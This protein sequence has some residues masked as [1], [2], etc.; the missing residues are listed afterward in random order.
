MSRPVLDGMLTLHTASRTSDA[1]SALRPPGKGKTHPVAYTTW[2]LDG[3]YAL[4][5]EYSRIGPAREKESEAV[6]DVGLWLGLGGH[7]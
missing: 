1:V 4:D 6:L 3:W 7:D 5:S 2:T